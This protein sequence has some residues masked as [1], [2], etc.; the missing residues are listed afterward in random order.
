MNSP[1]NALLFSST[2]KKAKW[3]PCYKTLWKN[4][5]HFVLLFQ[6]FDAGQSFSLAQVVEEET[7]E[8]TWKVVIIAEDGIKK[9]DAKK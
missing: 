6:I 3:Q 2:L 8:I 7:E 4:M 5:T 1:K 9:D